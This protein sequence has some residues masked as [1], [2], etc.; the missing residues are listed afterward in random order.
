LKKI[1]DGVEGI[2]QTCH[3][4]LLE[5]NIMRKTLGGSFKS[6]IAYTKSGKGGVMT[7]FPGRGNNSPIGKQ[8]TPAESST[9]ATAKKQ[10]H[11]GTSRHKQKKDLQFCD[12]CGTYVTGKCTLAICQCF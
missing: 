4:R 2:M 6:P 7:V 5:Q 11:P 3:N 10:S 8:S 12:D 9:I 1:L